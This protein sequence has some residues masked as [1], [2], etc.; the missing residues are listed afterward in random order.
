[1]LGFL[2]RMEAGIAGWT[3]T[4]HI[5][6]LAPLGD[7]SCSSMRCT[8]PEVRLNS[9]RRVPPVWLMGLSNTTLGFTRLACS[10]PSERSTHHI[11]AGDLSDRCGSGLPHDS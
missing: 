2:L 9:T 6:P 7:D 5:F 8:L 11:A 1:M 4:P 10:G 3:R